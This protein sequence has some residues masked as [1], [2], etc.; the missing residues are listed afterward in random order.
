MAGLIKQKMGDEQE[1]PQ[2]SAAEQTDPNAEQQEQGDQQQSQTDSQDGGSSDE[3][4]PVFQQALQFAMTALYKSGA[5]DQIARTLHS[6]NDIPGALAHTAYEIVTIAD[7]KTNGGIPD[8]LMILF[9]SKILEEIADI[10]TATGIKIQA[11]DIAQAIK[12]MILRYLGENGVDTTQLQAAMDK[13]PPDA[14][15]KAAAKVGG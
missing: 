3:S 7:E 9:A 6:T 5:A 1:S 13:V 14:F 4:N 12:Q 8:D 10:A 11:S 15:N 2:E